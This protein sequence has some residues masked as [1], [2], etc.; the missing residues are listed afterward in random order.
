[1]KHGAGKECLDRE[2]DEKNAQEQGRVIN[3]GYK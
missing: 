2:V 3:Y 1:M